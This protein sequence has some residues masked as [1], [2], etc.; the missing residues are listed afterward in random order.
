MRL[1]GCDRHLV[2]KYAEDQHKRKDRRGQL[3]NGQSFNNPNGIEDQMNQDG[4]E[5]YFYPR[6]RM[7]PAASY[8]NQQS[9]TMLMD[10]N[11]TGIDSPYNTSAAAGYT[12]SRNAGKNIGSSSMTGASPV[13]SVDWYAQQMPQMVYSGQMVHDQSQMHNQS[14]S[15]DSHAV[16]QHMMTQGQPQQR[17][18]QNMVYMRPND[19]AGQ[20]GTGYINSATV[21]VGSLPQH[22]DVALLHDLCA[23]Y[24]QIISAQVDVDPS[25]SQSNG[26]LGACSGRGRVQMA[27]LAQAQYATQALNGAIIFEGGRPLQVIYNVLLNDDNCF[28]VAPWGLILSFLQ[29]CFFNRLVSPRHRL[30]L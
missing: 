18:V 30:G 1:Q 13:N 3:S 27:G 10:Q 2:V 14:I 16:N 21:I 19:R 15:Y 20:Q 17:T 26:T 6:N 4:R 12:P 23:P 22:A 7:P 8:R 9:S 5:L 29:I 28:Y 11:S 25:A 24:G